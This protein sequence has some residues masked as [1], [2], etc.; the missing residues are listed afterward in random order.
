MGLAEFTLLRPR[1]DEPGQ[2]SRT[3]CSLPTL[4]KQEEKERDCF[5]H[6]DPRAISEKNKDG[7]GRL[8]NAP[9]L[10]GAI[11]AT[12]LASKFVFCHFLFVIC[13]KTSKS[14]DP[15]RPGNCL[16]FPLEKKDLPI[17]FVVLRIFAHASS[18]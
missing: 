5:K 18:H 6:G 15:G 3:Y 2:V 17:L 4:K 10:T 12:M 11:R 9:T 16:A 13:E 7:L 14:Q 8:A 1:Q